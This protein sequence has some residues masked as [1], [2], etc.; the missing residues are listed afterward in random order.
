[1]ICKRA[2]ASYYEYIRKFTKERN[3]L[4]TIQSKQKERKKIYEYNYKT[5][6]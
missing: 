4:V 3:S 5:K 2:T 1:M 6:S